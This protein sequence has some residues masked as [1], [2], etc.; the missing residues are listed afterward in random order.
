VLEHT[1]AEVA[2][3]MCL[4]VC[5]ARKAARFEERN[6]ERIAHGKRSVVLAVG[7]RLSGHASSATP[8]FSTTVA[9]APRVECGLP[10]RAMSGTPRRFR[11]G[12]SSTISGVSPEFVSAMTRSAA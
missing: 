3:G 7:A 2:A 8:T 12:S 11:W 10:V 4:G 9:I 5:L 6:R 1:P